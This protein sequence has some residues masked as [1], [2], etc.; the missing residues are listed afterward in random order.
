MLFSSK[1]FLFYFL[2]IFLVIYY[3][4]PARFKNIVLLAGSLYFYYTGEKKWFWVILFSI[5]LNFLFTGWMCRCR[6]RRRRILLGI[7]LCI[8]FGMLIGFKY[9]LGPP[10][11]ISFYTFQIAAYAIDVYKKPAIYERNFLDFATYVCMFPQLIAGPIVLFSDVSKQLKHRKLQAEHLERGFMLFTVGLGYKVLLANMIGNLWTEIQITGIESISVPMAW[12]GAIA[13]G[14]QLYFDFQGYSL[15]AMGLGDMLGFQIP[16]NFKD[17]YMA[18]SVTDFFRRWHITLSSWFRN[19]VYIPLGGNKK[20]ILR[21]IM[22]LFIVWSLT[23]IWHGNSW[24]FLMWG[25]Y[26]FVWLVLEKFIL[27]PFLKKHNYIGRIYTWFVVFSGWI[28]FALEDWKSIPIY[29]ER[30][31]L[32]LTDLGAWTANFHVTASALSRYALLFMIGAVCSTSLP[33]RIYRR[34]G[35][36]L[37]FKLGLLAVFWGSFYR[38]VTAVNNPFLYFRF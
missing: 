25:V 1:E 11:G 31:Y 17:P 3:L 20:G 28:I 34:F 5:C 30:M 18:V 24:N 15:M 7:L 27:R 4:V 32:H 26:Y 13:F 9:F 8:D 14:F 23:G 38:V 16:R 22:N 21:T 29:F 33:E 19:Y 37:W 6:K 35:N 2:P 12:L 36:K 10:L